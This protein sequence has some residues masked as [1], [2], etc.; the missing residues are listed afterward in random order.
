MDKEDIIMNCLRSQKPTFD[1]A[2]FAE[3]LY[4]NKVL[5]EKNS[6]KVYQ[7]LSELT[8]L[9]ILEKVDSSTYKKIIDSPVRSLDF[10]RKLI[11]ECQQK[12][13]VYVRR[14][15]G[16]F[17]TTAEISLLGIPENISLP[18]WKKEILSILLLRMSSM[19]DSITYLVTDDHS[20][21]SSG[22]G[23]LRQVM[24][25]L[26]PHYLGS[27]WGE[28]N[29]GEEF[30]KLEK[31]TEKL[32]DNLNLH[33][34]NTNEIKEIFNKIK[35]WNHHP[36]EDKKSAKITDKFGILFMPPSNEIDPDDSEE[37][38]ILSWLKNMD[39]GKTEEFIVANLTYH[40]EVSIVK[41]ILR[42]YHHYFPRKKMEKIEKLYEKIQR[43]IEIISYLYFIDYYLKILK[44]LKVNK[45]IP[46]WYVDGK[47]I[48]NN[49]Q[50]SEE[51]GNNFSGVFRYPIY[52]LIPKLGEYHIDS[53]EYCEND[54]SIKTDELREI[55]RIYGIDRS[56]RAAIFVDEI[57]LPISI[58]FRPEDL[59][60]GMVLTHMGYGL[61]KNDYKGWLQEGKDEA[62][63][64]VKN[65]RD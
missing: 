36:I 40:Q 21:P 8:T 55:F 59:D 64:F 58:A 17:W 42:K 31:E 33:G 10:A 6:K 38:E 50:L 12:N 13:E 28:D 3:E 22:A 51:Y 15:G 47:H 41:N 14:A 19:F 61:H 65:W 56:I 57:K 48:G 62:E 7:I 53:E 37:Q 18:E 20:N 52:N 27:H 9:K 39:E 26:I 49:E 44:D 35:K 45:F 46:G 4:K 29:D 5:E 11:T 34:Y 23:Y 1:V 25:E 54:L 30:F 16:I 60:L 32:I 24:L 2:T 63:L 43:G